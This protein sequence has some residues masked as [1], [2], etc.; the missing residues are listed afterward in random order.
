MIVYEVRK[1]RA[2]DAQNAPGEVIG[3]LPERRVGMHVED[4]LSFANNVFRPLIGDGCLIIVEA[5][6]VP[7]N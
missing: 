3:Y 4:A 7:C 5:L 1:K 2:E 6:L